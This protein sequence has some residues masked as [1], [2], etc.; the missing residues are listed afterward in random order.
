MHRPMRIS[1]TKGGQEN[2]YR[3]DLSRQNPTPC[4]I[5]QSQFVLHHSQGHINMP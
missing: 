2:M 5:D 4:Q 3:S 1:H